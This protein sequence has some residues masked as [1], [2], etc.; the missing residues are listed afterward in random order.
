MPR[1]GPAREAL[2][3]TLR[4][5][6]RRTPQAQCRRCQ[7]ERRA[8]EHHRRGTDC[9]LCPCRKFTWGAAGRRSTAPPAAQAHHPELDE[10]P[11]TSR[12]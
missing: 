3:R 8:H 12:S 6:A 9:A 1:L 2:R 4:N 7:H 5:L 10:A 11:M